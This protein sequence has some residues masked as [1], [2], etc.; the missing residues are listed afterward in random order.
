MSGFDDLGVF[1]SDN[2]GSEAQSSDGQIQLQAVKR[3][4]KEFFRQFHEGNF[5]YKYRSV[6]YS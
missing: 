5:E 6:T 4:F 3:R 1:Y 2:F